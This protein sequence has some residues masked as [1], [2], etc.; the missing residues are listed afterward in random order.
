MGWGS[1]IREKTIPDLGVK[2]T[3]DPGSGTLTIRMGTAELHIRYITC[4]FGSR[5]KGEPDGY[6]YQG[7]PA[8]NR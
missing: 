3:P 7:H 8:L 6:Y 1:E 2:T 4:G 5:H